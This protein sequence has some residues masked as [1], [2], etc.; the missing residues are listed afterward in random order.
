MV[1]AVTAPAGIRMIKRVDQTLQD[2]GVCFLDISLLYM[3]HHDMLQLY[4]R[5]IYQFSLQTYVN[6]HILCN[7]NCFVGKFEA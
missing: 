4:F 3:H 2:L 5:Y 7:R 1:Q 6:L